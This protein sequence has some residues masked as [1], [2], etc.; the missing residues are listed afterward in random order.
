MNARIISIFVMALFSAITFG[1]SVGIGSSSFTP[2]AMLEVRGTGTTSATTN[3]LL[4]NSGSTTLLDVLNNGYINIPTTTVGGLGVIT[5]ASNRFI[6]SYGTENFFAGVNAGRLNAG[7]TGT[8]NLGVGYSALSSYTSGTANTFIGSGA[9]ASLTASNQ[10]TAIG[11]G[12][13]SAITDNTMSSN[14]AIGYIAMQGTTSGYNT[15]VGHS[16][17][18]QGNTG[19]YNTAIGWYALRQNGAGTANVAIGEQALTANTAGNHNVAI[20]SSALVANSDGEYNIA[21]GR[22]SQWKT[23]TGDQ[24]ISIGTSALYNNTSGSSNVMIGNQAAYEAKANNVNYNIGIGEGAQYFMAASS[25]IAI[26][27]YAVRGDVTTGITGSNNIGLGESTLRVA[28]S[29]D[30]NIA[31][32]KYALLSHT[33]GDNNVAIGVEAAYSGAGKENIT[34]SN[35]TFIG[36]YAGP[37]SN[38]LTNATAI[39]YNATVGAS[40]SLVLGASANVG[41]GTNSP[42]F[43]F[44]VAG[45]TSAYNYENENIRIYNTAGTQYCGSIERNTSDAG[46]IVQAHYPS[47]QLELRTGTSAGGINIETLNTTTLQN[48]SLKP[49]NNLAIFNTTSFGSG[50][51][52]IGIKS[53]TTAPSA[54]PV[55]G[56][57][58]YVDAGALKYR[59]TSGTTTTVAPADPHCPVCGADFMH[60]WQSDKYGYLAVCMKCLAKELGERPYILTSPPPRLDK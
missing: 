55:G 3:L 58:L 52:V 15:A 37:G 60:E 40:N 13:L 18:S 11:Y 22:Q 53:A 5:Q 36:T 21:F 51:G 24:N 56:G 49:T 43:L 47:S 9:G 2:G 26:G 30:N 14:T 4:A 17:L 28:T 29:A 25:N 23:T 57:I 10:N 39:G 7:A 33:S 6:H 48:I 41:I 20:G 34:G 38:N 8:N 46:M 32:G 42:A 50:V 27:Y 45:G 35:N 19:G 44:Q 31:I 54:N 59:G 1:Q 16:A 12:A